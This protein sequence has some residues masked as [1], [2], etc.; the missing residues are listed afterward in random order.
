[1]PD[2]LG[3][4]EPTERFSDRVRDYV[5]YRPSYPVEVV[6]TLEQDAGIA[7]ERTRVVDLGCGTGISSALFLNRGYSVVGVEPNA[8]MRAA[9]EAA[10]G[11]SPRFRVVDGRAEQVPLP[12]ACCELVVAAQAF[13]WFEPRATRSEMQRLLVTEGL[14]ALMWNDRRTESTAFLRDYESILREYAGDYAKVADQYWTDT[15]ITRFFGPAGCER[16]TFFSYQDFDQAGLEGRALSSSYVPRPGQPGHD[17]FM[18]A[19]VRLFAQHA[20][21]GTVRFEYDT[22]LY[23]GKLA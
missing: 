13:H 3:E 11:G 20:R 1:M 21:A 15:E 18:R 2:P 23:F 8:A 4:L 17:D 5:R 7:P 14:V 16:R 19:L 10:L 22:R 9:A 12:D 6:Q